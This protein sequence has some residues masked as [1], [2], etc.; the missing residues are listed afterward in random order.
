[1]DE[2]SSIWET[3]ATFV[4]GK[5][6]NAQTA[7]ELN[8]YQRQC[9]AGHPMAVDWTE[10]PYCKADGASKTATQAPSTTVPPRA[11]TRTSQ[12]MSSHNPPP[13][14]KSTRVFEANDGTP[15]VG[16]SGN[17]VTKV[18]QEEDKRLPQEPAPSGR[19]LTGIV[20]TFSWTKLGQLSRVYAGRSYAG[21]A[22]TTREGEVTD[23]LV[24]EDTTMSGT[25]FLILYQAGKYRISDCNSTNGTFVNG[26]LIDPQGMELEDNAQILAGN[27][28]FIFKKVRPP[29]PETE[30]KPKD[31]EPVKV[32]G[33]GDS[34]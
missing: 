8:T 11:D 20:F 2:K 24:S 1:M 7:R 6:K 9:P 26:Q 5:N 29:T 32:P 30:R 14:R 16:A 22:P 21:T 34:V 13:D 12:T 25:H 10:C 4:G 27:T 18:F 15:S 33:S 28:L 19:P 23:V 3:L 31:Y 17:R